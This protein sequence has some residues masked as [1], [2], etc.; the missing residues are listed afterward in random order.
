MATT[1]SPACIGSGTAAAS[2]VV[3]RGVKVNANPTYIVYTY[4]YEGM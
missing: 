1:I 4:I 2:C 3:D